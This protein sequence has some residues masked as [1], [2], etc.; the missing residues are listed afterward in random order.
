MYVRCDLNCVWTF[1]NWEMGQGYPQG[2]KRQGGSQNIW[3]KNG[4]SD[5][6]R[7]EAWDSYKL[8][9]VSAPYSPSRSPMQLT[10]SLSPLYIILVYLYIFFPLHNEG[11]YVLVQSL[12]VYFSLQLKKTTGWNC[13]SCINSWTERIHKQAFSVLWV[14]FPLICFCSKCENWPFREVIF[15]SWN[16]L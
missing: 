14:V 15:F 12:T 6:S 10:R 4:V 1:L 5:I 3:R 13:A 16:R 9:F 8:I 2:G 7:S 11:F